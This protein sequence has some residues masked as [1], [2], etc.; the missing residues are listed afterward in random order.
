MK[1]Y[2][3]RIKRVNNKIVVEIIDNEF[4][5]YNFVIEISRNVIEKI[6]DT[7]TDYEAENKCIVDITPIISD[8]I[9]LYK[10]KWKVGE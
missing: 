9:L 1:M 5:E 8:L 4:L 3:S 10:E 7:I 2:S 6:I